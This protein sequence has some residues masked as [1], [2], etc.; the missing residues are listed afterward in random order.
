MSSVSLLLHQM[1]QGVRL[2]EC[3]TCQEAPQHL[4]NRWHQSICQRF[5]F[6][7]I[8]VYFGNDM[9][10]PEH[11]IYAFT[12][13]LYAIHTIHIV[14]SF[15][16][17][18]LHPCEALAYKS[19][20]SVEILWPEKLFFDKLLHKLSPNVH[21]ALAFRSLDATQHFRQSVCGDLH[22]FINVVIIVSCCS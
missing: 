12:K 7:Q 13:N 8:T 15:S 16:H 20:D 1:V 14:R 22:L 18:M 17:Y 19:D 6:W 9:P 2:L 3:C 5:M 21:Q 11:S 4:V 10:L